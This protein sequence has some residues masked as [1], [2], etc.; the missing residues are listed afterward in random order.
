MGYFFYG[1]NIICC[2][3]LGLPFL[4]PKFTVQQIGSHGVAVSEYR[5]MFLEIPIVQHLYVGNH[6]PHLEI[7][8]AI[9]SPSGSR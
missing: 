9:H 1:N 8:L 2:N 5:P 6:L 3:V 7:E 4:P